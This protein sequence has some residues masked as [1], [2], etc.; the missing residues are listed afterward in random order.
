MTDHE[1]RQLVT[2]VC[3]TLAS[4]ILAAILVHDAVEIDAGQLKSSTRVTGGRNAMMAAGVRALAEML[5]LAG[6]IA[7]GVG[8]VLA[9]V[10]WVALGYRKI[11][12]ARG[13]LVTSAG[14]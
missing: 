12:H 7:F 11:V 10:L 5:G 8:L 2:P 9:M 13:V 4:V 6:S 3:F 1:Q 14:R